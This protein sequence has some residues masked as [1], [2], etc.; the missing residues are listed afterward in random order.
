MAQKSWYSWS[1]A[2]GGGQRHGGESHENNPLP[3]SNAQLGIWFAQT[4]DPS[5]P[6]Y[7]LGEYLDISGP[8]D[9]T[10]F[11]TALRQVVHEADA[12]R[13]RFAATADG[14]QQIIGPPPDCSMSYID[15]S[16]FADP[17]A[18]AEQWM[19]ADLATPI[20]ITRGPLF[21]FA[22]FKAAADHFYWYARYHH[23][24]ADGVGLAL[25]ARRVAEIY[26]ALAGGAAIAAG[27]FGSLAN[28]IEDDAAYRAS[29]RFEQDRR[30]W[31]DCLAGLPEPVSLSDR[32]SGKSPSFI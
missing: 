28:L 3:L 6:T 10:L 11:E 1:P 23:I 19:Q 4:L 20:D 27:G 12:L 24:I 16:A 8:I 32:P 25:V 14:P 18:A 15:V 9:S 17:Q 22:L 21:G 30:Y 5:N 2:L 31:T 7:N 29:E 26:T 13:L